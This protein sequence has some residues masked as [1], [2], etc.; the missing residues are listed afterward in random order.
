MTSHEAKVA[1]FMQEFPWLR[2]FIDPALI[3]D[4]KVSRITQGVLEYY[5]IHERGNADEAHV[6]HT[7]MYLVNGAGI[8][9]SHVGYDTA[10]PDPTCQWKQRWFS[11]KPDVTATASAALAK[12]GMASGEVQFIVCLSPDSHHNY[13]NSRHLTIY[14]TPRGFTL[15]AWQ[16][17]LMQRAR[18]SLH[19]Q[20][21]SS[22]KLS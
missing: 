18:N 20:I 7:H 1:V 3:L 9:V 15:N 21:A 17:Q 22:D 10:K 14:K 2:N 19:Q 8:C 6:E 13:G 4:A 5:P 12:L 16:E 11:K